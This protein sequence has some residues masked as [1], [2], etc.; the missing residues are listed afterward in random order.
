MLS[1]WVMMVTFWIDWYLYL[2]F[3]VS[4][5]MLLRDRYDTM[6]PGPS[7]SIL[8]VYFTLCILIDSTP[9][10]IPSYFYFCRCKLRRL[11]KWDIQLERIKV[12]PISHIVWHSYF[13][14]DRCN[15]YPLQFGVISVT[16][17]LKHD[18]FVRSL[19]MFRKEPKLAILKGGEL[20]APCGTMSTP[21]SPR[22]SLSSPGSPY[23]PRCSW[24]HGARGLFYTPS[25]RK[26]TCPTVIS[27]QREYILILI[28]PHL[29]I[30]EDSEKIKEA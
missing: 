9:N 14:I 28:F 13:R 27:D 8:F 19:S 1:L 18:I 7:L 29:K 20:M 22:E 23:W 10:K 21:F 3:I 2:C 5:T 15:N 30:L 11:Y 6:K 16:H 12:L 4:S 17:E 25:D 26:Y 24:R